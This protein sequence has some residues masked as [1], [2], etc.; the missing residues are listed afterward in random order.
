MVYVSFEDVLK[1]TDDAISLLVSIVNII[2]LKFNAKLLAKGC[3][4]NKEM[5]GLL[6]I[7]Y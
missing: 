3:S 2:P 6:T 4:Y 5:K 7:K 1:C